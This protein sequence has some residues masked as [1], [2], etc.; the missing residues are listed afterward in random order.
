MLGVCILLWLWLA[1]SENI[2]LD[3]VDVWLQ[4]VIFIGLPMVAIFCMAAINIENR[5]DPKDHFDGKRKNNIFLLQAAQKW[6]RLAYLFF[7][8]ILPFIS[9]ALY[10]ICVSII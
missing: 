9:Y 5:I 3:K 8:A 1:E 6:V 4:Y 7:L 2:I 10:V